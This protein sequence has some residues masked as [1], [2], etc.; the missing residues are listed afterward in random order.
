[1]SVLQTV[2]A[3]KTEK[4]IRFLLF[5]SYLVIIAVLGIIFGVINAINKRPMVNVATGFIVSAIC[6]GL[7]VV[8]KFLGKFMIA[9]IIFLSF[10]TFVYI[11]FGYWSSPGSQSAMMYLVIFTIFV[12][13]FVA[14]HPL[15][16]FFPIVVV[17]ESILLLRTELIYTDHYYVYSDINYRIFD[18]SLNF[19]VVGIAIILTVAFVTRRFGTHSDELYK[20]SITDGLTGLYNRRYFSDFVRAEYN[21]ATRMNEPFSMVILDLNNFKKVNDRYGHPVGDEV[22]QSIADILMNNIRDYDIAARTGGDE[23]VIILPATS[24]DKA[25]QIVVR[26]AEKL[27]ASFEQYKEVELSVAFG[28]EDSQGKSLD[29]LYR[30]S[31]QKLYSMKSKQKENRK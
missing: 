31:D 26:I 19:A 2:K 22:L 20:V 15:E 24:K 18:L 29:E 28:I 11:P 5:N 23:F 9:R 7:F 1:M 14:V 3:L 25:Y 8:S 10:I 6:I 12:L 16:Y 13:S 4:D 17:I 30:I 21:R 27:E